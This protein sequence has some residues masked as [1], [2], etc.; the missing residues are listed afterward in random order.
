MKNIELWHSNSE[1]LI[2][3]RTNQDLTSKMIYSVS[4]EVD[5]DF[6]WRNW[7][8]QIQAKVLD[9]IHDTEEYKSGVV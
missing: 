1:T 2:L 5:L 4:L 3:K 9:F 8:Y 7:Y 6:W